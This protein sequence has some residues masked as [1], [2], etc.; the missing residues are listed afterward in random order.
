MV[1]QFGSQVIGSFVNSFVVHPVK[2]IRCSL[3]ALGCAWP[4][5]DK[6]AL[7]CTLYFHRGKLVALS[8]ESRVC[9]QCAHQSLRKRC[10]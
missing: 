5:T 8:Q 1:Q 9:V 7:V 4:W 2:G 10:M 3:T 6:D